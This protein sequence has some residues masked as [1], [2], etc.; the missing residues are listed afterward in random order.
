MIV[1]DL[2]DIVSSDLDL[3]IFSSNAKA[4]LARHRLRDSFWLHRLHLVDLVINADEHPS[5]VQAFFLSSFLSNIDRIRCTV[6]L[7]P[8][9]LRRRSLT[10]VNTSMTCSRVIHNNGRFVPSR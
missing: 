7:G 1:I 9:Q 10:K 3:E 2:A 6:Q 4:Q 8:A 5:Q